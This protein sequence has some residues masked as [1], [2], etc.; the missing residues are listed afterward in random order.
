M[1]TYPI[2][3]ENGLLRGFEMTSTWLVFA[4]LIRLLRSVPGVTDVRR[5]WF[6]SDRVTFKFHGKD[7][8]VH[9]PWGDN[10][11]YWIGLKEP[12]I[13]TEVDI[14]PLHEAFKRYH[15]LLVITFWPFARHGD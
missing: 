11:R 7:A 12:D 14:S 10:S 13:S 5:R 3:R 4:P 9:E 8:V 15:G 1:R 6:N 2:P